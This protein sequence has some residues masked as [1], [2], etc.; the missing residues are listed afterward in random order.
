MAVGFQDKDRGTYSDVRATVTDEPC[1]ELLSPI[2]RRINPSGFRQSETASA[3]GTFSVRKFLQVVGPGLLVCFADTDGPCL[4]TAAA[5]GSRYGYSLVSAQLILIPILYVVQELAVR[6]ALNT[7]CG[8]TELLLKHYGFRTALV[9]CAVLV[10]T[11]VAAVMSEMSCLAQ[12]G[13]L[14]GIPALA[15]SLASIA[16]LMALVLTNSLRKVEIIG[17]V[18]GSCQLVFLGVMYLVLPQWSTLRRV[19]THFLEDRWV[20]LLA[21]NIGAVIMPWMLF[22]QQ[23]ALA[24]DARAGRSDPATRGLTQTQTLTYA[25][26]D[27]ALGAVLTQLVMTAMVIVS[28]ATI[29]VPRGASTLEDVSGLVDAVTKPLGSR[30]AAKILVTFGMSGSCLAA[31]IV[32]SICPAWSICELFGKSR[33]MSDDRTG[34]TFTSSFFLV[35]LVSAMVTARPGWGDC[36]WMSVQVE[37]LNSFLMPVVVGFLFRLATKRGV[38]S[39]KYR[40]KGWYAATL[41]LTFSM[42]SIFCIYATGRD[43]IMMV[44]PTRSRRPIGASRPLIKLTRT[45]SSTSITPAGAIGTRSSVSAISV[46]SEADADGV[47]KTPREEEADA[48]NVS[49]VSNV[50]EASNVSDASYVSEAS[51][52]AE[53]PF[54]GTAQEPGAGQENWILHGFRGETRRKRSSRVFLDPLN[55]AVVS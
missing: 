36:A 34:R 33:T 22:Y 28:A 44:T 6:L 25:R 47:I 53:F 1:I 42:C 18:L 51:N 3:G 41:G 50:S 31:A 27:T 24:A 15:T 12:I 35:L 43:I 4:I 39:E 10:L 29:Y 5:S 11:C 46:T 9:A 48:S 52:T 30:T 40:V 13:T 16:L 8:L 54:P 32:V 19:E 55:E 45:P 37:V 23:S 7:G 17:V 14:W 20:Q 38:L 21:A 2:G 26:I 49:D